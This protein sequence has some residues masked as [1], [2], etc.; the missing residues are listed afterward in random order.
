L[1]AFSFNTA[2]MNVFLLP[3]PPRVLLFFALILTGFAAPVSAQKGAYRNLVTAADTEV[4][5]TIAGVGLFLNKV[6][7][8]AQNGSVVVSLI[9]QG[10]AGNPHIYKVSYTPDPGFVGVDT[11]ALQYTYIN[12]WPFLVY[13]AF[14][15]SVFPSVL[16]AKPDFAVTTIGTPVT[17]DVLANDSGSGGTLSVSAIPLAN[18]GVASV[19]G[20]NQVIF[21]PAPGF[22]GVAHV[23]YVVCDALGHCQTS[24]IEIG[25]NDNAAPAN[26]TL[27]VATAKNTDLTIPLTYNGYAVFQA[28]S[29]GIVTVA[30]GQAFHYV[31]NANFT[32]NDQFI[33]SNDFFGTTTYKT[34]VVEVLNTAAQ[35]TMAMDDYVFTPKGQP[36]TFNVRDNDIGNLLVKSWVTPANLPG[37][38]SGTTGAGKVTFTPNPNFTGVATFYYRIGNQYVPNLEMAAVNVIVG[39]LNPIFSTFEFTTPKESPFVVNYQIPFTNFEFDI[40]DDPKNGSCTIYPGF[41][42]QTINGQAVSGYNL[43]VYTPNDEFTGTD[44]FEINYCVTA[45]G[46]CKAVKITMNVVEISSDEPPPYCVQNCVWAGDINADGIVNNK[47]LLPLGYYMGLEGLDRPNASPEWYGQHAGNWDN[48]FTGNPIDVKH[49]D[50]DG[51]GTINC[52]DTLAL[53]LFYGHTDNLIPHIPPTSK[54]LPFFLNVLTPNPQIGDLVR[55][56]VSLGDASLPV[57][58]LYGFTFDVSLS[59]NIVDSALRMTYYDNSWLNLNAPSLWIDEN[60]RPRRLETAFTRTNGVSAHG[61][62]EIG[63]FNFIVIDIIHGGKPD[64]LTPSTSSS[65]VITIENPTLLSGNGSL[66]AGS[67]FSIEI[68]LA[69]KERSQNMPTDADFFVYPSPASDRLNIHLNGDDLMESLAIFDATGK[70]VYFSDGFQLERIELNVSDLPTGFYVASARTSSGNVVKKFQIAR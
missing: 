55:V 21:T 64:E 4:S 40:L 47:D 29:D 13:Q 67:N 10:G 57:T 34:V 23:N 48:P 26:D 30:N 61:H 51:D 6:N 66:T 39:N 7:P 31:P 8:L 22:M 54:N 70:A 69:S 45:N 60:P 41:S 3:S 19:N 42:T 56:E 2:A 11:F 53:S 24:H 38:I 16:S 1:V 9:Q 37:T 32:G 5:D 59:P 17:I 49:A 68:P 50:T 58:D 52:D 25:V 33:L 63:E 62:G 12:T 46:E 18:N 20:S 65:L 27:R 28:P 35:N 44:E 36:I 43:L 15:V 14:R